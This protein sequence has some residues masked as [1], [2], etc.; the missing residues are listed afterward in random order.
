MKNNSQQ[1]LMTNLN[2]GNKSY[3]VEKD[4]FSP[5][6]TGAIISGSV[7]DSQPKSNLSPVDAFEVKD[8]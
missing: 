5:T 1:L 7:E 4:G 3:G 8:E 6:D 2:V